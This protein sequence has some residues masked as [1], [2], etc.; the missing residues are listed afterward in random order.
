MF[1]LLGKFVRDDS[2]AAAIEYGLIATLVSVAGVSA[3][4][5]M[6]SSL[7]DVLN[8]VSGAIDGVVTP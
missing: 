3:L 8:T 2:G 1:T 5:S 6:G 7:N 4:S